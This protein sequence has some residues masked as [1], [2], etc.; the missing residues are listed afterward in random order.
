M[1]RIA[2]CDDDEVICTQIENIILNS[3]EKNSVELETEVFYSGE[4]LL[5]FIEKEHSFD[6]IF[7]DIEL[8]VMNG[9]EVGR[10]LRE[11]LKD[12]YIQIIY[13]SGNQSYSMEL[14]ENRPLQ[15][16]VKPI[17]ENDI[18]KYMK[19]AIE[20]SWFNELFYE[21]RTGKDLYKIQCKD[22]LYFESKNRKIWLY[23]VKETYEY[24]GKLSEIEEELSKNDFIRIHKSYLINYR[25]VRQSDYKTMELMNGISIAISQSYR[26]KVR[27]IL[28]NRKKGKV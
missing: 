4:E 11:E 15:F 1:F 19:K 22:I 28:I 16:L 10:K 8:R 3:K 6:L 17:L 23:T 20:L 2:I 25:F 14:F 24:Y 26:K 13:V 12:E 5:R 18:V 27:D 9:V 7:L 21:F